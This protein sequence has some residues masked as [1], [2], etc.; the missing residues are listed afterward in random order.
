MGFGSRDN[1]VPW[2]GPQCRIVGVHWPSGKNITVLI[3]LNLSV[4]ILRFPS[5]DP[6]TAT[7]VPGISDHVVVG[8]VDNALVYY[9][10]P[11]GWPE[12]APDYDEDPTAG[13]TVKMSWFPPAKILNG[14]TARP[15][16]NIGPSDTNPIRENEVTLVSGMPTLP[17]S[18]IHVVGDWFAWDLGF[19]VEEPTGP[20]TEFKV[21]QDNSSGRKRYRT[22]TDFIFTAWYVTFIEGVKCFGAFVG[23]TS[24]GLAA[25]SKP[26]TWPGNY[27][28]PHNF[29]IGFGD[30]RFRYK[31][32]LYKPIARYVPG[33]Y[34]KTGPAP[35]FSYTVELLCEVVDE[36]SPP[37]EEE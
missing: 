36:E 5:G 14:R 6:C 4:R 27:T 13:I 9:Q 15:G 31:E 17:G 37:S 11:N 35:S 22:G 32:K 19:T 12:I 2:L 10:P 25:R 1:P 3:V 30:A 18:T 24:G 7:D 28:D 29:T 8:W 23:D 21:L 33:P 26:N 34:G 20:Y 16:D